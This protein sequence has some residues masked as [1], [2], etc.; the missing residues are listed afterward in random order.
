MTPFTLMVACL[1][2]II[3]GN[4]E[5]SC[6]RGWID[7]NPYD[8]GCLLFD[9]SKVYTWN[10]AQ[11]F[12]HTQEE[13]SLVEIFNRDQQDFL[14][15]TAYQLEGFTGQQRSWFIGA[16]DV[17]TEGRWFWPTSLKVATFT[18]WYGSEP[19]SGITA[20]YAYMHYSYDFDWYDTTDTASYYPVCQKI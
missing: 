5:S 8:L 18:A 7:G 4:E 11:E 16:T 14:A 20:N 3:S 10:G 17:G 2:G 6:S 15:L 12:C 13:S 9:G 1:I 19:N